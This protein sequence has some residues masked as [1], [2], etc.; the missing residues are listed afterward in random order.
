MR[1]R[2]SVRACMC[3]RRGRQ[4]NSERTRLN[5]TETK[6]MNVSQNNKK[7]KREITRDTEH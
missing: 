5:E 7:N 3:M 2:M 6:G 1:K 4:Q